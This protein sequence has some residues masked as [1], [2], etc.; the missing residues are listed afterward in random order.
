[1]VCTM[2]TA[3]SSTLRSC[4]TAPKPESA[5]KMA[6]KT[7]CGDLK[8]GRLR[9]APSDEEKRREEHVAYVVHSIRS[10]SST[11]GLVAVSAERAA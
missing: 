10:R 8:D 5:Q 3:E 2:I 9:K 7:G 6:S 1:M 11:S 4:T